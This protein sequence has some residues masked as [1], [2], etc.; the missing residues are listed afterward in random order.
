MKLGQD[1]AAGSPEPR[2]CDPSWTARHV[3]GEMS[4]PRQLDVEKSWLMLR[5]TPKIA[6]GKLLPTS[7][8]ISQPVS[9]GSS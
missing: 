7:R 2:N 3:S 9:S 1:K 5:P 8:V 4:T 6:H